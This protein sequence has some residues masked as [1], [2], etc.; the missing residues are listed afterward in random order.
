[1]KS[2]LITLSLIIISAVLFAGFVFSRVANIFPPKEG[3]FFWRGAGDKPAKPGNP[4]RRFAWQW[5]GRSRW[6]IS[7]PDAT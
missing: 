2:F 6:G 4:V 3:V 1:M 5:E 7:L